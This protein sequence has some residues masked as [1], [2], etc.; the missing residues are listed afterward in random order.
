MLLKHIAHENLMKE[1][2]MSSQHA[3]EIWAT[4]KR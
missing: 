4:S 2:I 1:E 3:H